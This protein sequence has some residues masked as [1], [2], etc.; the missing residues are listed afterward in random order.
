[1]N[2]STLNSDLFANITSDKTAYMTSYKKR[3][4]EA[5]TNVQDLKEDIE[6]FRKDVRKLRNFE[7]DTGTRSRLQKY[8]EKFTDS[9]NEM[10]EST[11]EITDENLQKALEEFDDFITENKKNL[12]KLGVKESDGELSFDS[13]AFEEVTDKD[14]QKMFEGNDSLFK[15]MHKLMRNVEKKADEAEYYHVTRT[16]YHMTSYSEESLVARG[17][18]TSVKGVQSY[19]LPVQNYDND[20]PDSELINSINLNVKSLCNYYNDVTA[21]TST[22]T[23]S[24]I[25]SM[26]EVTATKEEDLQKL[27]ISLQDGKLSVVN[28]IT[29]ITDDIKSA[30]N[31]LFGDSALYATS[32]QENA[33]YIFNATMK[34]DTSGSVVDGYA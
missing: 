7:T 23:N 20:N 32:L 19:D 10:K 22:V 14:I 33:A 11:K 27:G 30:Y 2:V 6:S 3:V 13:E 15:K 1:M 9:Y 25:E 17:L 34:T 16:F 28:E 31:T 8:L 24:Y 26:K 18:F 21:K 4:R 5:D 29:E 12:K